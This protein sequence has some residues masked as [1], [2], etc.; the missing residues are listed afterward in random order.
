MDVPHD[1]QP[2][3]T[4]NTVEDI[5]GSALPRTDSDEKVTGSAVFVDDLYR[6]HMLHAVRLGS[7]HA[8]ARILSC[9][10]AAARTLPGVKS[11]ITAADLNGPVPAIAN[12]IADAADVRLRDLPMTPNVYCWHFFNKASPSF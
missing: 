3:A 4:I 2:T 8:H 12:A 11:V 6:P 5:I 1:Q 9:D 7:P 10:P